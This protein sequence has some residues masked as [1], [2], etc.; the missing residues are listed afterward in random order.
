MLN[1]FPTPSELFVI[2]GQFSRFFKEMGD[3]ESKCTPEFRHPPL[4]LSAELEKIK[5]KKELDFVGG[6]LIEVKNNAVAVQD[7]EKYNIENPL[8]MQIYRQ[9]QVQQLSKENPLF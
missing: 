6:M 5:L 7:D 4:V 3:L 1:Y 9:K 2:L 8:F